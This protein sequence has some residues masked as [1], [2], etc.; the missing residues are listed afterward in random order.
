MSDN[1]SMRFRFW[2]GLAAV[3]AIAI[4]S[5]AAALIVR[6]H[7][8]NSFERMQREEAARSAH[9]AEALAELSVGQLESAAAFYRVAGSLDKHQFNTV[10]DS[11]LR[12]GALAATA[13]IQPVRLS[14]RARYERSHGFPITERAPLGLRRAGRRPLY[15]PVDFIAAKDLR[16][17]PPLGYD[18]G[19]DFARGAYLLRARDLGRSVATRVM[20]LPLGGIGINVY[21]PVY[22]DGA[23]TD[24]VAERRAAVVGF[25]AGAF[26]VSD[27]ASVANSA[28]PSDVEVELR[29][30]SKPVLGGALS[31]DI[32]AAPLDIANRSWVLVIHDPNHPGIGLPLLMAVFGISLAALLGALVLVWSRNE[33]MR[34]LKRQASQDS[35]T[36]L[37]NRRRFEEDLKTEIARRNRDGHTGAVLMLDL[38]NFK[39]VND[40]LGHP[41][42]DLVI[43]EIA[44]TLRGR[45]R[46]TDVLAR[47]GGDEFAIV[48][49][50]CEV[51]EARSVAEA[52]ATGI[53][54]HVPKRND[55]PRITASIGIAIF[56]AGTG[57]SLESTMADADTAMYEA[58]EAGRDAVR[59][60]DLGGGDREDVP[61][62]P[63]PD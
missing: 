2:L 16:V 59:V 48:L 25:A 4:G 54:D 50:R 1:R 8:D 17:T 51:A 27:L 5:L 14:E 44:S 45:M 49:P 55:V 11:L 15:F 46:E 12:T 20:R 22:R 57:A 10:A 41:T 26:R 39:Q 36:G 3:V 53:R 40:T 42:G 30:G 56:G 38:D 52:I 7:E 28:L 6:S 29:E 60:F 19:S 62:A 13:F 43:A 34:E 9:Q 21:R 18:V 23:P 61:T 35:L 37:K 63:P 32:A 58:K 33:R 24:T 47:L 31:G